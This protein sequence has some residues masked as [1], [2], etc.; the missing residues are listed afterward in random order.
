MAHLTAWGGP[1]L[2]AAV[3]ACVAP[4]TERSSAAVWPIMGN[5]VGCCSSDGA[6]TP[7][8]KPDKP[9]PSDLPAG[10]PTKMGDVTVGESKPLSLSPEDARVPGGTLRLSERATA[11]AASKVGDFRQSRFQAVLGDF[12]FV[13]GLIFGGNG[14]AEDRV[15]A[16][17]D[18]RLGI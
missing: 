8:P 12:P 1:T 14:T 11:A 10:T 15:Q 5:S 4:L 7:H 6:S 13:F 17:S 3:R 2:A 16:N 9:S 18:A